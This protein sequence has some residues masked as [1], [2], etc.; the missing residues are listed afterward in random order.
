MNCFQNEFVVLECSVCVIGMWAK[1]TRVL[2]NEKNLHVKVN[3]KF[4]FFYFD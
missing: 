4:N 1:L 2:F 3:L